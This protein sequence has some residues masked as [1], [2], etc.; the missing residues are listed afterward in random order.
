MTRARAEA[1]HDQTLAAAELRLIARILREEAGIEVTEAKGALVASR[2]AKRLRALRLPG[3]E[4]YCALIASEAGAPERVHMISALTTNVTRFFREPHHF[5]DLRDRLAGA[6]G[7]R[8]RRGERVRLWSA[9]CSSGEEPYSLALT[10]LEALPDAPSLDLRI[11]ATDIDPVVL[12]RAEAGRYPADALDD[13]PAALRARH[14]ERVADDLLAVGEA[15]RRL[16]VV[17]PLNLVRRWP[18]RGPFDAIFCRNVA[19]YFDAETQAELWRRFASLLR[20]DG[21]L[22]IGHS[23]RLS[24]PAAAALRLCG[25]TTYGRPSSE[26]PGTATPPRGGAATLRAPAPGAAT[27]GEAPC[28]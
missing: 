27:A 8:A 10:V 14:F 19:I 21:R 6:L 20:P 25:T 28:R 16:V 26:G 7:E 23:E 17:R 9:G 22:H 11:L 4:A 1:G 18:L 12:A 3:F 13:V 24:G 2:L 15:P 5:D